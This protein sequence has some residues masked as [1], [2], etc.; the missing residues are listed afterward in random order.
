MGRSGVFAQRLCPA[1]NLGECPFKEIHRTQKVDKP[2]GVPPDTNHPDDQEEVGAA[3]H[4]IGSG[5]RDRQR[6][7]Y[8]EKK[9]PTACSGHYVV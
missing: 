1:P 3:P 4:R 8:G 7:E 5:Q 9:Q 6:P 2:N